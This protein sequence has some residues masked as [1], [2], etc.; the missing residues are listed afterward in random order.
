MRALAAL[1][2]LASP[3]Q[4]RQEKPLRDRLDALVQDLKLKDAR[5][6]V[7]VFSVRD[8]AA[9]YARNE[10]DPLKLASNTKLLTTAAALCR[11]GPDFAFRTALGTA[12]NDLHVFGGGDPNISGRFHDDDP[13]AVFKAWAAK[14]KAAGVAGVGDIVL[15]AGIFDEVQTHP[16]WKVHDPWWWWGAPFG[17]LS[18]NDNCV[19]VTVEPAGPGKPCKVSLSPDTAYVTIDNRTRSAAKPQKP[20]GFTRARGTNEISLRGEVGAKAT[21]PVAIHDPVRWFGAVLKET[22]VRCGIEVSGKIAESPASREEVGGFKEL[23]AHESGLL[24]TLGACN[25]PSQNFYAEMLLRTLGWKLKGKGTTANGLAAVREFLVQEVGMEEVSQADGSGL[26]RENSAAAADL[27]KLLL[28]MRRHKNGKEF[29][30]SLPA[31]GAP[32]GTLRSRLTAPE[33]KGR[34]RAKTGHIA[35]VSTLSGYAESAGGDTFVFSIL[36]NSG[37]NASTSPADRLQDQLCELL[38]RHKGD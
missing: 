22:L 4:S 9:V 25:K 5:V 6:G 7:L 11:L 37:A 23:A 20:F 31:N 13:T 8:G 19:D 28:Y 32:K 27:V 1:L 2:F 29:A 26:T 24:P 14:L 17:A 15:H 33:L 21:Y 38:L 30:E 16:E 36:V 18:L 35:G 34:L 12:G 10:R 3:V